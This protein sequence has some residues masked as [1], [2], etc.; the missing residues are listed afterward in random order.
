MK[1][2]DFFE[3]NE[4]EQEKDYKRELKQ[5]LDIVF[6]N[7]F[8]ITNM[9]VQRFLDH[10]VKTGELSKYMELLVN[11]FNSKTIAGL[12]CRELIS[13]SWDGK[14]FDCD[15]N[16]MMNINLISSDNQSNGTSIWSIESFD[17][18][19]GEPIATKSHCFG[20]TAGSGSSCSG[21]LS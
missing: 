9:P 21:M 8:T 11:N 19:L 16:Q 6:N 2:I 7:L 20:C 5:H 13:I 14:L 15:F 3:K 12:M 10:L 4:N 17:D 1:Y 18:L